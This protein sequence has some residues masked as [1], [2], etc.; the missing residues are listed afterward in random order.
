MRT[1]R[2]EIEIAAPQSVVWAVLTDLP[3]YREWNP[4]IPDAGGDLREGGTV[5]LRVRGRESRTRTLP[6]AVEVVDPPRRLRWV[7]TVLSP[8]LFRGRH[9]FKLEPLSDGRTRLVNRE[10]LSGVL[11][12]FVAD[13][14]SAYEAMNRALADRAERLASDGL[15]PAV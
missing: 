10:R 7:G 9:E 13:A 8:H 3:S 11:V 1:I 15:D 5:E 6:V 4:Q 2:T 12:P 14:D